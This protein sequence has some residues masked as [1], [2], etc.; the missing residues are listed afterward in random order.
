MILSPSKHVGGD[1]VAKYLRDACLGAMTPLPSRRPIVKVV[2][3]RM[4]HL[5]VS[6]VSVP[7]VAISARRCARVLL[8][9]R[10][11]DARP[12]VLSL[13]LILIVR[14][15]L[16]RPF[17]HSVGSRI[18]NNLVQASRKPPRSTAL[19]PNHPTDHVALPSHPRHDV[20]SLRRI[21]HS[22]SYHFRTT[23][24]PRI[25]SKN[26]CSSSSA[27]VREQPQ[28]SIRVT[29]CECVC[30]CGNLCA[31][32]CVCVSMCARA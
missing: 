1:T 30:E 7:C 17:R 24:L 29:P 27:S 11:R 19:L 10:L 13:P 31:W 16:A 14:V 23:V 3:Q 6:C 18:S 4:L 5:H 21:A 22:V 9:V 8:R 15:L 25:R 2:S 26:V 12:S 20:P 32:Q 28:S